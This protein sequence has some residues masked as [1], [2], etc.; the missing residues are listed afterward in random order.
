MNTYYCKKGCC[1]VK[2]Q[3]HDNRGIRRRKHYRK[4]GTF[5][6]DPDEDRVLLVQSRGDLWGPPKG[7]LEL[8]ESYTECAIRETKE[9]TGIDITPDMFSD[10]IKIYN[11][12]TFYYVEMKYKDVFVQH[13][14]DSEQ[15]DAN[16]I[17]WIK[18]ECLQDCVENGQMA[19]NRYAEITFKK[20]LKVIIR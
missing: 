5:I 20:F 19:L 4:A 14:E 1:K 7:T 3:H 9:E 16:G 12:A 2:I 18:V 17:T 8:H 15:N 10:S 6:Y 11:K 13:S